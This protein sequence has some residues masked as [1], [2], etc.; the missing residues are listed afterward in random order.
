MIEKLE[1]KLD[2]TGPLRKKIN[3]LIDE[4][5]ADTESFRRL[6]QKIGTL[7]SEVQKLSR[8]VRNKE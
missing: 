5:N 2:D 6:Y 7:E 3:E 8:Y 4:S 1:P